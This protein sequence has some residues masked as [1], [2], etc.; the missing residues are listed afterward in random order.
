MYELA[1]DLGIILVS[2]LLLLLTLRRRNRHLEYRPLSRKA[3][4]TG[5]VLLLLAAAVDV[6]SALLPDLTGWGVWAQTLGPA[7]TLVGLSGAS[8]VVLGVTAWWDSLVR[9]RN[10]AARRLRQLACIKAL[11]RETQGRAELDQILKNSL[12]RLV[13]LMGYRIGVAYRC[14]PVSSRMRLA[15]HTGVPIKSV[16]HLHDLHNRNPWYGQA[17]NSGIITV[18]ADM[19]S[20]PEQGTV[21]SQEDGLRSL[22]CVP[23]ALSGKTFAVLG[24][25]DV[26]ADR[27]SYQEN[28]FLT[29]VGQ[30]LGLAVE[31]SLTRVKDRRLKDCVS[32]LEN[33][34]AAAGR[35]CSV[36]DLFSQLSREIGKTVEFDQLSLVVKAGPRQD[37][38]V[39]SVGRS[40]GVL[41]E[42]RA[43]LGRGREAEQEVLESGVMRVDDD[44][45]TGAGRDQTIFGLGKIRS[46]IILPFRAEG[47]LQGAIS[48]GHQ[49]PHFYSRQDAEWLR[50]LAV[51]IGRITAEDE[52]RR[53]WDKQKTL[54]RSARDFDGKLVGDEEL[55]DLLEDV[56][57]SLVTHLP[58]SLARVTLLSRSRDQLLNCASYQIRPE[59]ITL[60][61][62]GRFS[63]EELPWHRLTLEAKRPM[64]I[65]QSD[66]ESWMSE[67]EAALTMDGGIG[68]ALLVPVMLDGEAVGVISLGE[69]RQWD[70]QP[71]TRQETDFVRH[72]ADQLSVALKGAL[73]RRSTRQLGQRLARLKAGGWATLTQSQL[74]DLSYRMANPLASI[75]GSSELLRLRQ[76]ELDPDSLRYLSNIERGVDRIQ[77]SFEEFLSRTKKSTD[78]EQAKADHSRST[79][80][81]SNAHPV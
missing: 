63:L 19:T 30:M 59:G 51:V 45:T 80:V 57:F 7:A 40:G 4:I 22:A 46:R 24:L 66:P 16:F 32:A 17:R 78:P 21:F 67:R 23:I 41:V 27:F 20:L 64:L 26:A 35:R 81:V 68:S 54:A 38:R 52:L 6:A 69:M 43:G 74:S 15:A 10:A 12:S 39:F 77:E 25:Y 31:G 3:I 34:L 79:E 18:T 5:A 29:S 71:L 42:R 44:L 49:D 13:N 58:R 47:F 62:D 65:D 36:E 11:L 2:A 28:Q 72:R 73:L 55:R 60:R 53:Q 61:N 1:F 50:P 70:R 75:R 56:A 37:T 33:L 9:N 14:E 48:L 8:L 76:P